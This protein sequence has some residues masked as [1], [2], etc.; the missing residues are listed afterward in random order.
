V[1]DAAGKLGVRHGK[2]TNWPRLRK[3]SEAGN[4]KQGFFEASEFETVVGHLPE[5]LQDAARFAYACGWRKSEVIG[6]RWEWVDRAAGQIVLADS[7][8][9]RGRVLAIAGDLVELVKRRETARLVETPDGR[10]KVAD[11]VFHRKGQPLGD[12]KRAWHAA[13]I[14][15]GFSH[16]VKRPDGTLR[17]VYDKTFHD[18]RRTAARNLVRAGIREGVAMTVTGHKTRSVFDR[19]NITSTDDVREAMERVAKTEAQ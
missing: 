17:T 15:A 13:L 9:G 4:A 12:F 7:K 6:L 2:L 18:F 8:N 3:L 14:K 16:Q 5:H 1:L 19:Y 10:F 11:L